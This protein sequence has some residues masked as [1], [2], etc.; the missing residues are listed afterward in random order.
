MGHDEM[1]KILDEMDNN[2]IQLVISGEQSLSDKQRYALRAYL[3]TM[4]DTVGAKLYHTKSLSDSELAKKYY[5]D[6]HQEVIISLLLAQSST[7]KVAPIF[8]GFLVIVFFAVYLYP[9]FLT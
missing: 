8:L 5:E 4:A 2:F 7:L 1:D 6:E 3:V 9:L